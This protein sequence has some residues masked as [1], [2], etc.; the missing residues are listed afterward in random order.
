MCAVVTIEMLGLSKVIA[1]QSISFCHLP[2]FL[3]SSAT[4]K[5]TVSNYIQGL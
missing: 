5:L 2:H 3:D 4:L 1:N